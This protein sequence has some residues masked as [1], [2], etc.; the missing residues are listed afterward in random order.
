MIL[1]CTCKHPYQ[2]ATYGTGNRVHNLRMKDKGATF[3]GWRCT[4]CSS[5][6]PTPVPERSQLPRRKGE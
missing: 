1:P 3:A 6:K 2:D 5:S 4:V